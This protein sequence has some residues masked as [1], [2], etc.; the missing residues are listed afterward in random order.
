MPYFNYRFTEKCENNTNS[1]WKEY[2]DFEMNKYYAWCKE[3]G[4]EKYYDY[5]QPKY[6]LGRIPIGDIDNNFKTVNYLELIKKKPYIVGVYI[7]E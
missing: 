6:R 3:N 4:V 7:E 1:D 2:Y 5:T